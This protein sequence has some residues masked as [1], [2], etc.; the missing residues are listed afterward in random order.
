[1]EMYKWCR[2]QAPSLSSLPRTATDWT[3]L[4]IWELLEIQSWELLGN[5]TLLLP[6]FLYLPG[7]ISYL[8]VKGFFSLIPLTWHCNANLQ[9]HI[10]LGPCPFYGGTH[11]F[12]CGPVLV[13]THFAVQSLSL[14][15]LFATPWTVAH[16]APL[17]MGIS[18]Q[19]Y[20]VGCHFLLQG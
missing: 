7:L 3:L 19:E 1:M 4:G 2:L 9:T 12:L 18:K 15:G 17:S 10:K 5:P 20:E 14:I 11:S 16:Q 13:F 8:M 6:N